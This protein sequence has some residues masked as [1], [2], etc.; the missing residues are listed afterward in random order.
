LSVLIT[1]ESGTGKELI[2]KYIH[3]NSPRKNNPFI[4]IDCATLPE[5]LFESELFGYE[6]GAFTGALDSKIG[7]FELANGGTLFLDEIGNLPV[8]I[9]KKLL[10]VLQEKK[11]MRIGGKKTIDLD[12]RIVCATNINLIE[13]IKK[14][15][16]RDDL[17]HRLNEFSVE[18]PPLRERIGDINL[19]I[20]KFIQKLNNKYNK[21]IKAV[22]EE[23]LSILNS[24]NWPGNV[25]E[26]ENAIKHAIIIAENDIIEK[27]HLPK[28]ILF[29]KINDIKSNF[30]NENIEI[31]PLKDALQKY[32]IKV[33]K[34]I[35]IKALEYYK[36]NKT[37][38]AEVLDIDYKTLYNKIKEYGIE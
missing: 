35:I 4:S 3:Y 38:V 29:N 31:M 19:L 17:Y 20:D 36:W 22:S 33:E 14:G 27:H 5:N 32:R 10:R 7:R 6:K 1:G 9:Q 21:N 11:I 8:N 28:H 37:K 2:A 30:N 15:E 23:A 12:V 26:L 18:L 25:R 24:Y 34:E 13:A 16:F